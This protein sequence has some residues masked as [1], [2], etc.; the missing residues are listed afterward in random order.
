VTPASP[1]PTWYDVLGVPR[2]ASPAEIK[3]AWR[4]S[5]DKF[6]PGS[7][8]GQFRMFNEAADVLLDPERRAAYDASLDAEEAPEQPPEETAPPPPPPL[9]VDEST[10]EERGTHADARAERR[11]E[12]AERRAA[13]SATGPATSFEPASRRAW[14]LAAVLALL[15]VA[16]LVA[17]G[18]FALQVRDDAL[19]ADARDDAPAAAERAAKA[20]FEY[21]YRHLSADRK[22][23][24]PYLT[25]PY[26]EEYRKLSRLLEKQKDGTPG[27][28]VQSKTVVDATVLGSGVVDADKDRAR[29]LVYLNL[30]STRAGEAPR[31]LQNRAALSMKKKGNRWLVAKVDTY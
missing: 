29:V 7:G 13:K 10:G 28:A 24:L 3:A 9:E 27:L 21:D 18:F 31:S 8:S 6:E 26:K 2:D 19:A 12:R 17:A 30:V 15:T 4:N 23:A 1:N 25:G 11:R 22:R 5:T 14:I 16:A 20:T